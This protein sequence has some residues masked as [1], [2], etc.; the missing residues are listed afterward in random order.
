MG[1]G[2]DL[3]WAS[4][5]SLCPNLRYSLPYDLATHTLAGRTSRNSR[6]TAQ[7]K[8]IVVNARLITARLRAL[9][10]GRRPQTRRPSRCP[11]F[12]GP[13]HHSDIR[14]TLA[15][16]TRAT[17]GLQD[18]TTTALE[19][20]FFDPAV[21][22]SLKRGLSSTAGTLT[23]SAICRTFRSGGTRIRTGDT[24][25]FSQCTCVPRHVATSS[26]RA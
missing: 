10:G 24:M 15:I 25:I 8:S 22:T 18:S 19:E 26:Q 12:A 23:F 9:R 7:R 20:T 21:D 11:G 13:G 16:Y 2:S 6:C 17:E 1:S 4:T 5:C 3:G 14:M